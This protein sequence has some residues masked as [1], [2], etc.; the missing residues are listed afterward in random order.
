MATVIS[1]K[2]IKLILLSFLV[3]VGLI[4]YSQLIQSSTLLVAAAS[5]MQPAL[6]EITP[7]YQRS[8]ANLKVNYNF[9]SSG[10]LEQ[11]IEQIGRAHV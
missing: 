3:I 6:K 2:S 8:G 9:G 7:L 4:V 10:A 11:Q 1:R 5:S